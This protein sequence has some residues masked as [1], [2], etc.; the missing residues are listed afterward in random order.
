MD[1]IVNYLPAS[2]V[3]FSFARRSRMPAEGASLPKPKLPD[4]RN[5]PTHGNHGVASEWVEYVFDRVIGR[6]SVSLLPDLL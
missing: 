5:I 3:R 4:C 1:Q 6:F 2:L